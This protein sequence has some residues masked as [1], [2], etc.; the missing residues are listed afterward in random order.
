[1]PRFARQ[2]PRRG[3]VRAQT[4]SKTPAAQFGSGDVQRKESAAATS[5]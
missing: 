2:Q 3:Q 1:M 4:R 5:N